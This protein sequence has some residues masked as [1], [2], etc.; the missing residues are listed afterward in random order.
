MNTLSARG[1]IARLRAFVFRARAEAELDE[2]LRFHLDAEAARNVAAGMSP[3]EARS[4]WNQAIDGLLPA[5]PT[6]PQN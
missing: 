4:V 5:T 6:A 3:D 1:V 2:E